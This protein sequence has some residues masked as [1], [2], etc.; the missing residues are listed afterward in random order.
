MPLLSNVH[1]M[2]DIAGADGDQKPM[3]Q[4]LGRAVIHTGRCSS[5][6]VRVAVPDAHSVGILWVT[7]DDMLVHYVLRLLPVH[8]D[9]DAVFIVPSGRY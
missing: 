3:E 4:A 7:F 5:W 6:P 1:E 9:N 2:L 8:D